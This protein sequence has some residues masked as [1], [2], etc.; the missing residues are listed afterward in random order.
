[1]I[2]VEINPFKSNMRPNFFSHS[3]S[4][5]SRNFYPILDQFP[6]LVQENTNEALV[7]PVTMQEVRNVVFQSESTNALRL[8]GLNG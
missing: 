4:V 8:D 1:M 5:G 6:S 3:T 7:C 2:G